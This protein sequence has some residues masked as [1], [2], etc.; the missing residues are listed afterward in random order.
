MN[1][2]GINPSTISK[3]TSEDDFIL[4]KEQEDEEP[5]SC[6][7]YLGKASKIILLIVLLATLIFVM[8]EMQYLI[9]LCVQFMQW[10]KENPIEGPITLIF[11]FALTTVC[12]IPQIIL[13]TGAG[14]VFY[15]N[16]S[17]HLF[18][19]L[20]VGTIVITLGQILGSTT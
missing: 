2:S 13:N 4:V 11:L 9:D 12:F 7:Q 14:F 10:M 1:I 15:S 5:I 19:T 18:P 20:V 6:L 3:A 8:V 16:Y 17:Q